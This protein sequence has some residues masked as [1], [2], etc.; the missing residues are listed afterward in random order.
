MSAY[1][2]AL[3][4]LC[5]GAGYRHP[6]F[7]VPLAAVRIVE[8]PSLAYAPA[9]TGQD[10]TMRI[11]PGFSKIP[12]DRKAATVFHELM[13]PLTLYWERMGDRNPQL[14]NIA[15]DMTINEFLRHC[16][17]KLPD[18]CLYPSEDLKGKHAEAIYDAI[19]DRKEWT[20][21]AAS[22]ALGSSRPTCGC[23]RS[24][25]EGGGAQGQ[26]G[27]IEWQQIASRARAIAAGTAS[28]DLIEKLLSGRPPGLPWRTLLKGATSRSLAEHGRDEQT[29]SRR[30]R[31][32]P[33]GLILPGW[34][35]VRA[36]VAVAID[37]S[38]SVSDK[39]LARAVDEVFGIAKHSAVGIFLVVHDAGVFWSGWVKGEDRTSVGAKIGGRG[40]T[41]FEKAYARVAEQRVRFDSFVHLTDGYV[42]T[43]PNR[44]A[45]CKRMVAAI[46]GRDASDLRPPPPQGTVVVQVDA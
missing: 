9:A 23:G 17:L 38:G 7:L 6:F 39:Q 29:W 16:G 35:A 43:W 12:D 40:G 36:R 20:E 42:E 32:S 3:R 11:G 14:W 2:D 28:G 15:H 25:K 44:P 13:H 31:R 10:G 30:N 18:G 41:T 21:L 33:A 4:E 27:E 45:N 19:K 8:D 5:V 37:A 24:G 34:R 26:E 22:I 1:I 46:F